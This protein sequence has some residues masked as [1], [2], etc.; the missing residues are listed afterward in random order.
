MLKK[1]MK[2]KVQLKEKVNWDKGLWDYEMNNEQECKVIAKQF[3]FNPKIKP[4]AHITSW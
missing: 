3:T 2:S 1:I 4:K